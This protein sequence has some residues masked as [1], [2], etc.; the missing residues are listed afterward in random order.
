MNIHPFSSSLL[1]RWPRF[2]L[3]KWIEIIILI[4][5]LITINAIEPLSKVF[6]RDIVKLNEVDQ[7]LSYHAHDI[8]VQALLCRRFE[9]DI[10]LHFGNEPEQNI[11]RTRWYQS[12]VALDQAIQQ[13]YTAAGT[14]T[15]REQAAAWSKA[16]VEYRVAVQDTLQAIDTG[17]ITSPVEANEILSSAKTAIRNLTNTAM[18]VAE[19]KDLAVETSSSTV[20]NTLLGSVRVLTLL[21]LVGCLFWIIA[22]RN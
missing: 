21:L 5:M 14:H 12:T 20:R 15:D 4:V 16:S 6:V 1:K 11:Y 10:L 22:R 13:F 19:A 18:S 9:K 8:V 2:S 3:R 17:E 7:Q